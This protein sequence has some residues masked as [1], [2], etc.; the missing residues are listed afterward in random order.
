[1]PTPTST[2]SATGY[3]VRRAS[4]APVVP[5]PC[6]ESTRLLTRDD[7]PQANFHITFIRDSIKHYHKE[8]TELYYILEGNGE[9]ELGDD[10]IP[11]EPGMLIRIEPN[12]PHRLRSA[13]GVRTLV[14]GTP[15]LLPE[16]EHFVE[17]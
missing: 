17:D 3:L 14:I 8:C 4:E 2:P 13:L 12:T 7:G 16:D 10:I 6:G 5:C 9:M 1:M 11:V 15:A